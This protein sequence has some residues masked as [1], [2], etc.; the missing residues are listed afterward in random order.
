MGIQIWGAFGGF[1]KKAGALVGRWVN[2]QNV[3]SAIPHP[4]DEPPSEAQLNYRAKFRLVVTWLSWISPIIK[5][6]FQNAHEERQSAFNAAFVYNYKNAISGTTAANFTIDYPEVLYSK[7][8]LSGPY[9][10][11]LATTVD[12]QLDI[13]W[14]ATIA[15]GIGAPTD[16]ATFVVYNPSKQQ[17]VTVI[18]AAARSLLSYDMT[19]PADFSGDNCH[20][21]MSFVS[22]S[23]KVTS[24][25]AYLGA[26][27]VM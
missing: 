27:V 16:L 25:S 14:L 19:L 21:Y 20:V 5:V 15:N 7:G 4:S 13:S 12:A 9:F 2:G 1:Q 26:T 17:F 24:N 8:R 10:P 11:V 6:G 23:G 3:I 22:A 18:G